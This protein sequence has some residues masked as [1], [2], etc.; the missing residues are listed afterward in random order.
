MRKT[1]IEILLIALTVL[2]LGAGLAAGLLAAR[3][4]TAAGSSGDA[5]TGAGGAATNQP[6]DHGSLVDELGL[7]AQ[8]R[9]QMREI[10][11]GTRGRVHQVFE[12]AQQLQRQRDDAI[13]ALLNDDQKAKFQKLSGDYADRF[14][15]LEKKR[16]QVFEEA[17]E[18]TKSIL[19]DVQR[20]KYEQI[21]RRHV[22]PDG[23]GTHRGPGIGLPPPDHGSGKD[24][25][26]KDDEQKQGEK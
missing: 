11:E 15:A 19:N 24:V 21:L 12:D 9:D 16:D 25:A 17:V 26:G 10:W 13:V 5:V 3:L 2:A 22:G 20:Q 8:Q 7:T 23:P 14:G 1:R 6:A 4:P 18:K